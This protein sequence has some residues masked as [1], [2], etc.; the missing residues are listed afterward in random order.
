MN[1]DRTDSRAEIAA[2]LAESRMRLRRLLAPED[3]GPGMQALAVNGSFPRSH[4][5]RG[6]L[7]GRTLAIV[8]ALAGAVLVT[9]PRALV[10][11]GRLIP[12]AALVRLLLMG[13]LSSAKT[14]QGAQS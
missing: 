9:R 11:L 6:L 8:A 2:R 1:T 4:T 14:D 12:V 10:R 3:E 5:M 13:Y 7:S